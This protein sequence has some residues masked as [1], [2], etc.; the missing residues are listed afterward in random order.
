M[1][2]TNDLNSFSLLFTPIYYKNNSEFFPFVL[3][4]WLKALVT[5]Y[6]TQV[7]DPLPKFLQSSKGLLSSVVVHNQLSWN[8]TRWKVWIQIWTLLLF[9]IR[10]GITLSLRWSSSNEPCLLK[11]CSGSALWSSWWGERSIAPHPRNV[12]CSGLSTF[13]RTPFLSVKIA[14]LHRITYLH[15][16]L[17]ILEESVSIPWKPHLQSATD[18]DKLINLIY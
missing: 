16:Y 11:S 7:L 15:R 13:L 10:W 1:Q 12:S 14:I 18:K 5:P 8:G 17:A 2:V 6:W 3:P 9:N 4:F